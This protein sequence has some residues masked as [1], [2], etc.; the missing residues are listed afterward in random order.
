MRIG[1]YVIDTDEMTVDELNTII[2]ELRNIRKRKEQINHYLLTIHDL[3]ESAKEEGLTFIDKNFGY[4]I[5]S[6]GFT[7]V[8]E[9]EPSDKDG[10]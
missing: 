3:V 7:M 8:D 2:N 6:D 1:R 9:G 5:E 4:V 10:R